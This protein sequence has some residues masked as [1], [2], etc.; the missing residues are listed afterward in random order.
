MIDPSTIKTRNDAARV[1]QNLKQSG[2]PPTVLSKVNDYI[3]SPIA[4]PIFKAIGVEKQDFQKGL[5]SINQPDQTSALTTSSLLNG[6]D[7]LK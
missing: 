6:I 5:Q 2:L 3:N 7:Q 4:G 1:L